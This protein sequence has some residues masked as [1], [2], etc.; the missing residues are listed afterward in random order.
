MISIFNV[1]TFLI[2]SLLLLTVNIGTSQGLTTPRVSQQATVSQRIGITDITIVYHSP[3]VND[4][5]I[6]GGLVPFDQ[7]W[8]T[9]ANENTL[10]TFTHHVNIEG[11]ALAAG[12][13]GLYMIPYAN[14]VDILFSSATKNWGTV[15]PTE[16]EL[17]ATVSVTPEKGPHREW[18]AFDFLDRGGNST[19][20]ALKWGQ[21]VIPFKITVNVPEVVM[22]NMREELKGLAGFGYL[23][24]EQAARYALLNDMALD[25]AM[26]WIDGSINAEKR[27]TNLS[28]K[29]GLLDK[30]GKSME[31]DAVMDEALTLATP[32]QMNNYGYQLLNGGDVSGATAVFLKNIETCPKSHPFYWGF[33]DSVGEGYLRS[34]DK[35]K[36]LK[37]Y[38]LAKTYAPEARHSYLDGVINGIMEKL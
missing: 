21:W 35:E 17:V 36:A 7:V 33:V 6:W 31:A 5:K 20:A 1:R 29:A 38:K 10:I 13:Y 14:R 23:G 2:Y 24:R 25:E 27:F 15:A 26:T 28:V 32:N 34:G 4:R 18:L 30:M 22:N 3:A 19:T 16:E 9:G 12:T 11:T 37:Y 8:R